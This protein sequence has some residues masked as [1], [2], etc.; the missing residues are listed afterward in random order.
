MTKFTTKREVESNKVEKNKKRCAMIKGAVTAHKM[1]IKGIGIVINKC[2]SID[3]Q[4]SQE[5][6]E[7]TLDVTE[8]LRLIH[9]VQMKT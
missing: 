3:N 7:L 9:S 8:E 4:K 2:I 6:S 5:E 1:S